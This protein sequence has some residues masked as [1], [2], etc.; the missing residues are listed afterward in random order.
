[1]TAINLPAERDEGNVEYKL[2]VTGV[3]RRELERLASQMKYRLEEGGGEAFYEI[4]VTDDGEPIGLSKEQLDESIAN[5]EKAAGIIGAK[6]KILR[7]ERG[8]KGLVAEVHVRYSR[9]DRYPVFVTIPLLG[10]VDSGKSSLI[11]VLTTGLLD[12]GNGLAMK[13]VARFL[14]EVKSGR[15]SS[16][17]THLLGFDDNGEP[18]NYKLLSPLDEAEIFLKS[19][20]IL[21]FVDLA[22]HERYLRTTL[23]GVLGRKPDY[24]ILTVAANAGMVGMAREHLG[25]AIALKL[26]VIIVVTKIDLVDRFKIDETVSDICRL[27]KM[28]GVNRIPFII[29][30]RDDAIVAAKTIVSER[31]TPIFKISNTTG[32]GL[33]LIRF[34]LDIVPPRLRWDE[35]VRMPFLMYIDDKFDV[36]GVGLVVSGLAIQGVVKV[37]D[38]LQLGPFSDGSFRLVRV[39]S[40][41]VCRIP[42]DEAYSGQDVCLAITNAEYDEV[43][44]GMTLAGEGVNLKPVWIFESRIT[45]LHHPTTIRRGYNATIHLHTIREAVEFVDMERE[46]LRTGD[47]AYVKLRFK[48]KPRFVR[49][50]DNFV[51]REGR[52]R[53]I[54]YIT[55]IV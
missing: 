32:E 26:P 28:P 41:H 53:G 9:E 49:I 25:V 24:A 55:S 3:G 5:L 47:T 18:V 11:G 21:C 51:F 54:G 1:M 52:T 17:S 33:D 19:A 23:K 22:G 36:K 29:R 13:R 14:H 44:K 6:L 8:R 12:D 46:P 42:V 16:I 48:Y 27:L 37:G 35:Y 30:N 45:V 43:E 34:F 15:T 50:G 7:I 40:I 2:R 38:V 20:K 31:V 4:G 39:K 10:N